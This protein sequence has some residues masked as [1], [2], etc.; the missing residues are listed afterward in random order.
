MRWSAFSLFGLLSLFAALP[1]ANATGEDYAVLIISRERL[2]VPT[3]CEIGVYVNDQL[4][5]RL[6]QEQTTSFNLPHGTLSIRLKQLPG[7]VPGCQAGMLA[8]P[9]QQISLK[10]GD[11]LKYRIAANAKGLYLRPAAL[12]Y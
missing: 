3:S 5:G 1:Q 10:A 7:Q 11:V 8:P 12:E 9:A 2:E 6:L 4:A